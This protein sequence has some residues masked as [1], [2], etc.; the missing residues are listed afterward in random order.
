ML[1]A[2]DVSNTQIKIG[3]YRGTELLHHWRIATDRDKTTDEYAVLLRSLFTSEGFSF[4]D[5]DAAAV[6]IVV[7]PLIDTVDRLARSYLHTTPLMVSPGVRTGMRILY[8]NPKEVGADRICDAVAAYTRYGGPAIVVAFSTATTFSVVTADGEFL[9]GAIAPGVG[10]SMDALAEHTAQ[11]PRIELAK[12]RNAIGRSTVSAMQSGFLYGFVGQVEE[13]VR[14]IR[15]EL[16]GRAVTIATGGWAELIIGECRCF[17][18][19]DPLLTLEGL[20]LIHDRNRQP[21]QETR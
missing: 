20:R 15:H 6:S 18:H 16:G 9:G 5:V 10:I 21:V 4:A 19:H 7:P 1:L 8:E 12:P 14:R 17:D 2:L 13:I 11:L 3:L